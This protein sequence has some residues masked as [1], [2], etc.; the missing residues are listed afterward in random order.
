MKN[1][2]AAAESVIKEPTWYPQIDIDQFDL[3]Y[4]LNAGFSVQV[5]LTRL[6]DNVTSSCTVEGYEQ[7]AD[8]CHH[9]TM[10]DMYFDYLCNMVSDPQWKG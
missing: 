6:S 7:P 3:S 1:Y 10:D 8:H 5:Q 2:T 4:Y 9:T